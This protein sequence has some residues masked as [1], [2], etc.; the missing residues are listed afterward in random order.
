MSCIFRTYGTLQESSDDC[1]EGIESHRGSNHRSP[2]SC[3]KVSND[4]KVSVYPLVMTNITMG[5]H[6]FQWI[7]PLF[8]WPFSIAMFNY[9]RVPLGYHF[10]EE[11]HLCIYIYREN[12]GNQPPIDSP[13][14]HMW[15]TKSFQQTVPLT[16]LEP[17]T[18]TLMVNQHQST[19]LSLPPCTPIK[20]PSISPRYSHDITK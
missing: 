11:N 13:V 8:L 5:N 2:L 20:S 19:S 1:D 3:R 15:H 12:H 7:N 10:D 14:S 6:L 18:S 4:D 16:A 17:M 9:Q